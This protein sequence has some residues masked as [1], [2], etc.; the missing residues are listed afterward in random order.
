C[1]GHSYGFRNWFFDMW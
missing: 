1:A